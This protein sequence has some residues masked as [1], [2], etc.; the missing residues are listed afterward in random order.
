MTTSK[1]LVSYDNYEVSALTNLSKMTVEDAR[2]RV[3]AYFGETQKYGRDGHSCVYTDKETGTRCA[4][5]SLLSRDD[6]PSSQSADA[7]NLIKAR[8][9]SEELAVA[10]KKIQGLHDICSDAEVPVKTFCVLVR[11]LDLSRA[12]STEPDNSARQYIT[13]LGV[14]AEVVSEVRRTTPDECLQ[15]VRD[16]L[17]NL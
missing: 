15:K 17:S 13:G 3:V 8:K 4:V 5:G 11:Q 7:A 2:K 6:I 16:A 10:A 1:P 14:T 9:G 12:W